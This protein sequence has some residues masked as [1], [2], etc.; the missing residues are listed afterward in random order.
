MDFNSLSLEDPKTNKDVRPTTLI[1][2][3]KAD[4]CEIDAITGDDR[5]P[6]DHPHRAYIETR[7]KFLFAIRQELQAAICEYTNSNHSYEYAVTKCE[8][9]LVKCRSG[10][11]TYYYDFLQYTL[12]PHNGSCPGCPSTIYPVIARACISE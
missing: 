10:I 12:N 6:K 3:I 2:A 9:T 4:I 7:Y 1:E 8:Q 11:K 5:V